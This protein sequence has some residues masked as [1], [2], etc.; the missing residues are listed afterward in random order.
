MYK[1]MIPANSIARAAFFPMPAANAF[2]ATHGSATPG[3]SSI[4]KELADCNERCLRLAADFDNF[5]KRTARESRE[6]AVEL[7]NEFVR[8]LLPV[9]DNLER[10]LTKA[11]TD[12]AEPLREGVQ[13]TRRQLVQV[14]KEHGFAAREYLRKHFDPQFHEAVS[15]RSESGQPDQTILKEW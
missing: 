14:L 1:E 13:L 15:V 6:R 2:P 12:A 8:A 7:R 3:E 9:V 11:P 4:E 5:K 10:A